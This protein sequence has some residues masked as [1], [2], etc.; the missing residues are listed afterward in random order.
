VLALWIEKKR[1]NRARIANTS[2]GDDDGV[3]LTPFLQEGDQRLDRTPITHVIQEI[4]GLL[5]KELVI[6]RLDGELDG[7]LARQLASS[8]QRWLL[9]KPTMSDTNPV[10]FPSRSAA[11]Q[12]SA[13]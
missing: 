10:S 6:Q 11:R 5:C 7:I 13:S 8:V 2:E 3:E 9:E 1:V 4:N 12:H